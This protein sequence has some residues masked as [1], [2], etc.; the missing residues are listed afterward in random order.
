MGHLLNLTRSS[1]TGYNSEELCRFCL[2]PI[3]LEAIDIIQPCSCKTNTKGALVNRIYGYCHTECLT[4]YR[5]QRADNECYI[6]CEDCKTHYNFIT[7]ELNTVDGFIFS[8]KVNRGVRYFLWVFWVLIYIGFWT[9]PIFGFMVLWRYTNKLA[10]PNLLEAND[11]NLGT[12]FPYY[13][14]GSLTWGAI[15]GLYWCCCARGMF[16][17][18]IHRHSQYH[19]GYRKYYGTYSGGGYYPI[20]FYS[21]SRSQGSNLSGSGSNDAKGLL[22]VALII[23]ILAA[24]A[25]AGI[26]LYI[27]VE[28]TNLRY[29][30]YLKRAVA[31]KYKVEPSP[32]DYQPE[33][34]APP[35]PYVDCG[36]NGLI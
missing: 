25:L 12:W 29:K 24:L 18:P 11:L 16:G 22:I 4:D 5:I 33:P 20:F 3:N 30:E 35:P 34:S 13:L 27:C 32:P 10:F 26:L 15:L 19:N 28:L 9:T 8:M 1:F 21:G 7:A 2:V 17:P 23:L 14:L 6:K 31:V 36:Y